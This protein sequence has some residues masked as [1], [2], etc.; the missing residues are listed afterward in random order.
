VNAETLTLGVAGKGLEEFNAAAI[1]LPAVVAPEYGL[2]R[3]PSYVLGEEEVLGGE[4]ERT[5]LGVMDRIDV[6][7]GF[8]WNGASNAEGMVSS[9][10]FILSSVACVES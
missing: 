5:S 3:L 8:R 9:L 6:D 4:V 1:E 2:E 10:A 7:E